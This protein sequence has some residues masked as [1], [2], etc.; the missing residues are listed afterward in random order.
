MNEK[1][2]QVTYAEITNFARAVSDATF[3]A[4]KASFP[5][6]PENWST[7]GVDFGKRWAK[8][9]R[10]DPGQTGGS[11]HAFICLR[12]GAIHKAAGWSKPAKT[13][14]GNIRVGDASNWWAGALTVYG[15]AYLR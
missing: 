1:P 2:N 13:A 15:A 6:T 8:L 14:R 4:L 5:N 7:V 11:A 9:V 12:T 10:V 3:N